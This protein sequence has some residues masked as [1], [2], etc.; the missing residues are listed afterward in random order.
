MNWEESVHRLVYD[1]TCLFNALDM[2]EIRLNVLSAY[3]DKFVIVESTRTFIGEP[4]PLYYAE[5][6]E[7][8]KQFWPKIIHIIAE[9]LEDSA[10]G[11]Y[12]ENIMRREAT[13]K[14]SVLLGVEGCSD[15][16]IIM[17]SDSDEIPHP[18]CVERFR[19]RAKNASEP[20]YGTSRQT[21]YY[22]HLNGFWA[23]RWPG[24]II[25]QRNMYREAYKD[26]PFYLHSIRRKGIKVG[27]GWHFTLA[28]T[29]DE[30]VEM[31]LKS[32]DKDRIFHGQTPTFDVRQYI[33]N[34]MRQGLG[35]GMARQERY[36][37]RKIEYVEIDDSFPE[38][39]IKNQDKYK[40]LIHQ[41][42]G[43][44]TPPPGI[45]G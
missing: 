36:N 23:K 29:M 41:S 42:T 44:W 19:E 1:T 22:W 21:M 16:D 43:N 14:D 31:V 26:S 2:L 38:Y 24:T 30:R 37:T 32:T 28:G 20:I 25:T 10:T 33:E 6:K 11:G 3:V 39:L 12:T 13:H 34:R 17:Y 18:D 35:L 4:K 7:R 45:E 15:T 5:N 27:R 40:H 8:F 9:P